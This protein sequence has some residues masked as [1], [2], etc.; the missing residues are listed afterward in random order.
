MLIRSQA[1]GSV[2]RLGG[3]PELRRQAQGV[4]A[5]PIT[6]TRV[7]SSGPSVGRDHPRA[8][9]EPLE[10]V[11]RAMRTSGSGSIDADLS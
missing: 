9:I 6:T 11:L 5:A 1:A 2:S 7:P 10:L 8:N 3:H 4:I